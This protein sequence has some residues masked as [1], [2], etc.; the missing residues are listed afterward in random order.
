M[1][2]I[3]VLLVFLL[4]TC[5]AFA[6]SHVGDCSKKEGVEKARC[7]RHEKMAE[8]CGPLKGEVHFVCDREFL[9]ANP[10]SCK[11][12]TGKAGA[13]C[14]AEVKAFKTCEPKQSREFMKCV[15]E[16]TGISPM[17]H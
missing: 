2:C 16:T 3:F 15:R 10:L 1:K 5:S 12:F 4:T 8:K 13:E 17:G 11:L 7:E 9:L 14:E 6:Q